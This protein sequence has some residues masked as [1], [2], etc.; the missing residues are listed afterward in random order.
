MQ[1]PVRVFKIELA[2]KH[3]TYKDFWTYCGG[4]AAAS[5]GLGTKTMRLGSGKD[6]SFGL[7]F[8]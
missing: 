1:H 4:M 8:T 2:D 6:Q 5:L 7:F 3:F